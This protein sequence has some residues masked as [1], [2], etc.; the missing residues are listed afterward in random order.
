MKKILFVATITRHITGFHLS[1]LKWFKDKGYEVHVA[2]NGEEHIEYCDHHYNLQFERFPFKFNNFK[3]YKELKKIIFNNNYDIIH[4][5]TPVGGVLT[6]LAARKYRKKGTKVIYTAHGFHFYKGA[7]LLNW[8]IYYPTEKLCSKWTDCLITINEEDYELARKKFKI[9]KIELVDGVGVDEE[10]FSKKI[11]TEEKKKLK[12]EIGLKDNDFVIIQVGELNTN[13]NQIM[14]IKALKD[15][16][17]ENKNVKLLLVGKGNL[18]E[19]YKKRVE[20][21]NLQKQVK[22]L[23]YRNDIVQLLNISDC[24]VSTSKR[25][26]LPVNVIEAMIFGIY[27]IGTKCRGNTDLLPDTQLVEIDDVENLNKKIIGLMSIRKNEIK[28]NYEIKKYT[29]SQILKKMEKIYNFFIKE[30]ENDK[31]SYRNNR[32]KY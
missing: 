17:K 20:D 25:E 12:T 9:K 19:F 6:R 10:K 3:T 14:T 15:I 30:I 13:K 26:G 8:L 1:Y 23:G 11:S 24:L 4:C 28:T 29:K 16:A 18:E 32:N 27:I 5:H 21:Y 2:S 7:P 31:I 22:F